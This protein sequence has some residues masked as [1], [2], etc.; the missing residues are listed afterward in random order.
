MLMQSSCHKLDFVL[1][2]EIEKTTRQLRRE[3]RNIRMVSI[4]EEEQEQPQQD[5]CTLLDYLTPPNQTINVIRI[6]TIQANNFEIQMPLI[7]MMQ[8][9]Q[10]G[11]S[12]GENLHIH[13]SKFFQLANTIK[14]NG[15]STNTIRLMLFPFF[16]IDR[17]M[18]WFNN[19]LLEGS[20][21]TWD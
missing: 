5:N 13:V 1:D 7:Q 17:V 21:T 3:S 2:S 9:I 14:M 18:S 12:P 20:I 15:I 4:G 19:S 11:R 8:S 16:V 10:F 6:P